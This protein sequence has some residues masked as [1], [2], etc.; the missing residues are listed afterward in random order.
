ME[1]KALRQEEG[2]AVAEA[3]AQEA[4]GCRQAEERTQGGREAEEPRAHLQRHGPQI[5]TQLQS[6]PLFLSLL[7]NKT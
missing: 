7:R 3:E 1:G 5:N 6:Q 2:R 4:A